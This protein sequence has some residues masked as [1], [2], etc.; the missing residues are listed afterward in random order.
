MVGLLLE[1]VEPEEPDGETDRAALEAEVRAVTGADD[2]FT[3]PIDPS[4]GAGGFGTGVLLQF[5]SVGAD[6]IA[7]ASAALWIAPRLRL[8]IA[9]ML[10]KPGVHRVS[11]L[12]EALEVLVM[13]EVCAENDLSAGDVERVQRLSHVYDPAEPAIEKQ[14]L[15]A[16]Y[17]VAVEAFMGDAYRVW[18]TLV[19]CRGVV[20]TQSAV[21]VPLPNLSWWEETASGRMLRGLGTPVEDGAPRVG[22]E[23]PSPSLREDG[24]RLRS[25]V[26]SDD[27]AVMDARVRRLGV[28]RDDRSPAT[29]PEAAAD[30]FREV[31][32][33][34]GPRRIGKWA[35]VTQDHDGYL[36]HGG[37]WGCVLTLDG[38]EFE[39]YGPTAALATCCALLKAASVY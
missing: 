5:V 26:C 2:V 27:E 6:L 39:A 17:T 37:R 9:R 14:Q 25:Y 19:T 38:V 12:P 32:M 34:E 13:A 35:L 10:E 11:L 1:E 20:V 8:L 15:N 18:T 3:A 31:V 7:W 30:A 23:P 16:A 21:D 36:P 28:V 24:R 33:R 4:V 22:P 29:D